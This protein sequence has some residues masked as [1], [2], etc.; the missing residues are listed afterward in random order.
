[1]IADP[2]QRNPLTDSDV[3]AGMFGSSHGRNEVSTVQTDRFL[4]SFTLTFLLLTAFQLMFVAVIVPSLC[5]FSSV[6]MIALMMDLMRANDS[7][8]EQFQRLGLPSLVL[9]AGL[10][11]SAG[12]RPKKKQPA[13]EAAPTDPPGAHKSRL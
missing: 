13:I 7:P 9:N 5:N 12:L 11:S 6:A 2:H 8:P 4:L 1:M 3:E 10:D